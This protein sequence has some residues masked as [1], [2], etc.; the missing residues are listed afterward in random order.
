MGVGGRSRRKGIC[1]HMWLI[2]SQ[3][4][5]GTNNAKAAVLQLKTPQWGEVRNQE[6]LSKGLKG[7]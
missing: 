2:D 4:T 7:S 6:N 5:A 3:H 1:V